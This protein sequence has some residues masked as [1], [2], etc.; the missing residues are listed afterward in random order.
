M[1]VGLGGM[2]GGGSPAKDACLKVVIMW[3]GLKPGDWNRSQRN[4]CGLLR[5]GAQE[6]NWRRLTY[7]G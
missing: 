1:N 7:K 5:T 4:E 6:L 2:S 3:M